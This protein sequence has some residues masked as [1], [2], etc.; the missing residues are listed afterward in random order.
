[1]SYQIYRP[2][3]TV[4]LMV[5]TM[6]PTSGAGIPRQTV[7]LSLT[8]FGKVRTEI[9]KGL[10][11]EIDSESGVTEV[12]VTSEKHIPHC[13]YNLVH[14]AGH[15][16]DP[17]DIMIWSIE[18]HVF[19]NPRVLPVCGFPLEV[20]VD[21]VNVKIVTT[22]N[23]SNFVSGKAVATVLPGKKQHGYWP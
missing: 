23:V 22:G 4:L 17:S 3:F 18:K 8:E 16:P 21:L 20:R 10:Y 9:Q 19:N 7:S 14:W 12:K 2:V 5:F 13:P 15:G 1:M 6:T 11:L